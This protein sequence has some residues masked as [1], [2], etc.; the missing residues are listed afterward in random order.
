ML[1]IKGVYHDVNPKWS[2]GKARGHDTLV[3]VTEGKVN[4]WLGNDILELQKGEILY[5]P[6]SLDRAWTSHPDVLHQKY[7]VVFS[8]TDRSSEKSL[9]FASPDTIFRIKLLNSAYF[10][11]R[12]SFL[13]VQ[14]MGKR[15]YYEQMSNHVLN[16]LFTL[17]AQEQAEPLASPAKERI[18]RKIQEYILKNFRENITLEE[19]AALVEIS[20]NYVTVLFKEVIGCTPI[21]YLHQVRINTALTL[22][23]HTEMTVRDVAEFLGY[24]DQAYFNRMFKK[25]MGAAPTHIRR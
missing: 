16:E 21:Q 3:F 24:C 5:I 12:F 13:Y 6:F 10:N 19:L 1:E 15:P 14:W 9:L 22:F 23:D 11:Q 7:T 4:Y 17:I 8:W 2:I 25:W 18:A 20:P